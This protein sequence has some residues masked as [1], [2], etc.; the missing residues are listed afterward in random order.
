MSEPQPVPSPRTL[1]CPNCGG[2]INL[3]AEGITVTAICGQCSSVIDTADDNL[4]II[5]KARDAAYDT[6]LQIG[7]RGILFGT[8]WEVIGHMQKAVAGTVYR[9]SEYLLFNPWQGFRF[10]SHVNGHWTF[11]KRLNLA[12][13]GAGSRNQLIYQGKLYKVFNKDKVVVEL[14]KGEFYWRVKRG[15]RAF[16]A[17]YIRPPNMLSVEIVDDEINLSHGEYVPDTD[18]HKAFPKAHILYPSGVGAC[19]QTTANMKAGNVVKVGG[20]AIVAAIL[21]HGCI[22]V[23][24]PHGT[25]LTLSDSAVPAPAAIK[26]ATPDQPPPA[27]PFDP[28]S[29]D[30]SVSPYAV[31]PTG[32]WG[33]NDSAPTDAESKTLTTQS[34]DIPTDGSLD[35]STESQL[36]NA[37]A[38]FDLT[39]VNETNGMTFPVHQSLE[40]YSGVDDGERWSEGSNSKSDFIQ[41][42]PKGRYHMLVDVDSDAMKSYGQL[43]FRVEVRH[44]ATD[45]V[46]L[47]VLIFLLMLW[48][49]WALIRHWMYESA[50]WSQSDFTANST[51][52]TYSEDDE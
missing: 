49:A 23:S 32:T 11:F 47:V 45:G 7:D 30:P 33:S 36:D 18:M 21:L 39:L 13:T 5:Q 41:H 6:P 50:R 52:K 1:S 43:P 29:G 8:T 16:A 17:D 26:T 28:Y 22:S 24:L 20:A 37:W 44:G 34:F 14:V 48:P 31:N 10:L 40:H 12:I 38:D 51:L 19:Q 9:W 42:I 46:N 25:A 4:R 3:R 2:A 35:I 27:R 15:D